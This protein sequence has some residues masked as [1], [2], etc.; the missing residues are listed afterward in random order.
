MNY[1][2][3]HDLSDEELAGKLMNIWGT[4]PLG[5]EDGLL[6]EEAID[7]INLANKEATMAEER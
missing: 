7:R 2:E 1:D 5:S 4:F 3:V 6:I